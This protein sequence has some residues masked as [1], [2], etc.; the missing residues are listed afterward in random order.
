M[1]EYEK[2]WI[3]AA[4]INKDRKYFGFLV[5]EHQSTVRG[6]LRRLTKGNHALADDLA[7]ETFLIA[8]RK[9]STFK[10]SGSFKG[11]LLAI[12]YRSFLTNMRKNSSNP[13]MNFPIDYLENEDKIDIITVQNADHIS[14]KIDIGKAILKL[15]KNERSALTLCYTYGMSHSEISK[16]MDMPIGTVKS[17]IAR[18]KE[19]LRTLLTPVKEDELC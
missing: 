3:T 17:H 18:G 12:A 7:Q 15:K 9:V 14:D 8:F 10:G 11:W 1:Q 19:T 6:Y 13:L 4:I 2:Q 16:V 5:K